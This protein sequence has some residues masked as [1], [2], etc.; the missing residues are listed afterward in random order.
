MFLKYIR[1]NGLS[2]IADTTSLP[3]SPLNRGPTVVTFQKIRRKTEFSVD[4]V[5]YTC[6]KKGSSTEIQTHTLEPDRS[7]QDSPAACVIAQQYSSATFVA[8]SFPHGINWCA[9][10]TCH[11]FN[12]S[13]LKKIVGENA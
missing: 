13:N 12:S 1:F 11:N 5:D 6:I 10:Q 9:F 4:L 7:R 8:L 3:I 2:A